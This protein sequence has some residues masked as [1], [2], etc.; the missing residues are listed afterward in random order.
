[1]EY[2]GASGSGSGVGVTG[3]LS[4]S[5]VSAF[6]LHEMQNEKSKAKSSNRRKVF[7]TSKHPTCY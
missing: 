6:G 1:M 3:S 7:F 2:D 4:F 5:G